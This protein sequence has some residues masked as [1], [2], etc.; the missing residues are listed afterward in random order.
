M[1]NLTINEKNE[2]IDRY[3]ANPEQTLNILVDLQFASTDGYI[4]QKTAQLVAKR[5]GVTETRIYEL[6]SFYAILKEKTQ[7]RYVLKICNSAPC[8]FSGEPLVSR[9]LK[10]ILGVNEN[11]MTADGLFLYHGIPCVGAC[12]QSPFI[13]IKDRV[14]PNLTAQQIVQLISDLRAGRYPA[15]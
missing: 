6:I 10:E 12:A 15:L 2:I 4:D 14:F 3:Q 8:R 9:S 5:V 1:A 11:E 13:K 7:A